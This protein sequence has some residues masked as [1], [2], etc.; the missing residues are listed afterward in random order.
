[1]N[2][3][4]SSSDLHFLKYMQSP[5]T[6]DHFELWYEFV[7]W[8]E[9]E[10]HLTA[11]LE[12]LGLEDIDDLI[13]A[14]I[15]FVLKKIPESI[16]K[17]FEKYY[18]DTLQYEILMNNPSS[19]SSKSFFVLNQKKL[20][21]NSTWLIHFSDDAYDI[22]REG[23]KHGTAEPDR[24]GL[25]TYTKKEAKRGGYNFAFEA[26]NKADVN[27]VARKKKYGKDAVMFQNSGVEVNHAGDEED[28]VV[29]D[30]KSVNPRNVIYL[31]RSESSSVWMVNIHPLNKK[32][33]VVYENE[34]ISNV[35][36][37]V[38]KNINQYR[39]IITAK[40]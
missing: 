11:I 5:D 2:E 32:I 40:R 36:G 20:L 33:G 29:F 6:P 3:A 4:Y 23:F 19:A 15:S 16:L 21:P 8:L 31:E 12:M 27:H 13:E 25:T 37:W 7:E 22:A 30:G 1:M 14:D 39:N 17:S 38:K 24:L 9:N 18:R 28:Q 35:I 10:D 34:D 26:D